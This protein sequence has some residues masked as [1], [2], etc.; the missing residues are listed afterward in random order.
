MSDLLPPLS[1]V[2][3][4]MLHVWL[5]LQAMTWDGDVTRKDGD[6]VRIWVKAFDIMD[7]TASDSVLIHVDASPP[8][9]EIGGLV[10]HGIGQ[11][12]VFHMKDLYDSKYVEF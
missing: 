10:R 11:L 8:V 4:I 5:I 2:V 1:R 6:S 7:N 12:A 9:L 3:R